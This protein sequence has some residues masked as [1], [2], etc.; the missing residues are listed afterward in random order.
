M[1][2]ELS[3]LFI[4]YS[5]MTKFINAPKE[6]TEKNICNPLSIP[7]DEFIAN[8]EF[9]KEQTE[10]QLKFHFTPQNCLIPIRKTCPMCDEYSIIYVC[11]DDYE[12]RLKGGLVQN[13]FPYLSKEDRETLI[14]NT[15]KDCQLILFHANYNHDE[16]TELINQKNFSDMKIIYKILFFITILF[17][18]GLV[19]SVTFE[20][21]PFV[22]SSILAFTSFAALTVVAR[23]YIKKK[24]K[25]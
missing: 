2:I 10:R 1:N 11:L 5:L 9:R 16:L 4:E 21:H 7:Y 17:G 14:S 23:S 18:I 3:N 20:L 12:D 22:P 13:C 19:L 24:S 8:C 6:E 15:C 25:K